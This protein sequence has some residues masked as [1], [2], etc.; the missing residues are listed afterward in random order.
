ME[1]DDKKRG[2]EET[3]SLEEIAEI[4]EMYIQEDENI[5]VYDGYDISVE[6]E[7]PNVAPE[8]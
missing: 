3:I 5:P 4:V 1:K 7:E 8:P 2:I 6:E